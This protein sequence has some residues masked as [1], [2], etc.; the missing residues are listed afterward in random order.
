MII[1]IVLSNTTVNNNIADTF[2]RDVTWL[3]EEI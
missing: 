2:Q 1:S 3:E